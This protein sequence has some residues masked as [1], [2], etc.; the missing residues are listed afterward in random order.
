[1]GAPGPRRFEGVL[2]PEPE[3]AGDDGSIDPRLAEV[4][5]EHAD[6]RASVR[7]VASVLAG[8]RLMTPLLA[9]LDEAEMTPEGLRRDKSSHLASVSMLAPDG[10]R[11]LLAFTSVAAMAAWDPAA[12]GIPAPAS[13]VAAAALQEGA[14][15]VL[16][17]LAGPVRVAVVGTV[18]RCLASGEP[19]P[20]ASADPDV[21]AAVLACLTGVD[22]LAGILLEPAPPGQEGSVVDL[23]VLV[24]PV[25]GADVALLAQQVAEHLMADRAVVRLCPGGVAV[26]VAAS[27]P[28]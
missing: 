26:G 1:M 14:D 23:L 20:A 18:L 21:G 4:L 5:S 27:G 8:C 12:R 13:R 22:G 7:D 9:V 28:D 6:G 17:D 11:G 25:P 15:A 10:R 24:E 3:F 2:V 19:V 16:L